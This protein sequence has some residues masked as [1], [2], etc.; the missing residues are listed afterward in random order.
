[1]GKSL[2]IKELALN[3]L[4]WTGALAIILTLIEANYYYALFFAGLIIFNFIVLHVV[5]KL[6]PE[7]M[8][9][10]AIGSQYLKF[11][12]KPIKYPKVLD[13]EKHSYLP[14]FIQMD[15]SAGQTTIFAGNLARNVVKQLR[16]S[17]DQVLSIE[18]EKST[19]TTKK[20]NIKQEKIQITKKSH[21]KIS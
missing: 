3:A 8:Q 2:P 18:V 13:E 10:D 6:A 19:A 9:K 5:K 16:D 21:N 7:L 17:L 4:L 1:M 15:I 11:E 14:E 12:L 20:L